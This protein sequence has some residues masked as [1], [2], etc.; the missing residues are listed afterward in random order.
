VGSGAG[1][2]NSSSSSS[3]G[4]WCCAKAVR[5]FRIDGAD[6][7][8]GRVAGA[9]GA[10]PAWLCLYYQQVTWRKNYHK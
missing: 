1:S 6:F 10:G 4:G 5:A 7:N 9:G 2:S 3:N 8:G